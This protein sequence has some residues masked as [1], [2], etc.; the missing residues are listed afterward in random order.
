[1]AAKAT[2]QSDRRTSGLHPE[3]DIGVTHRQVSFGPLA[4]QFV[5]FARNGVGA[6]QRARIRGDAPL[7]H[8]AQ[9]Q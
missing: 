6:S 8:R 3:A 4:Q 9:R 2:L 5:P 1:M 7:P